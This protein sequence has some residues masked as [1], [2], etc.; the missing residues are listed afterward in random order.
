MNQKILNVPNTLPVNSTTNQQKPSP[1]I[2]PLSAYLPSQNDIGSRW[3]AQ[4]NTVT[5]KY[6]ASKG[7]I[8]SIE[9]VYVKTNNSP[10]MAT[11]DIGEFNSD[12]AAITVFSQNAAFWKQQHFSPW[13]F[14]T[15]T[16]PISCIAIARG[17]SQISA[18][19]M[20]CV[21]GRTILQ[22]EVNGIGVDSDMTIIANSVLNRLPPNITLQ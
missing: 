4:G 12:S 3:S 17:T 14:Q 18:I 20:I 5:S 19:D 16:S 9:Q 21:A 8:K 11:V 7:A 2:N 13:Q 6:L 10:N 15:G 22:F 1:P